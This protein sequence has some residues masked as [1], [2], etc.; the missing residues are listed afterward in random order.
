MP[1]LRISALAALVIAYALGPMAT[2]IAT[3]A[4]PF[5]HRDF[6]IS[7]AAAQTMISVAFAVIAVLR[8]Y[9]LPRRTALAAPWPPMR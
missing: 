6:G 4:V 3:P 2:Q 5:V 9:W 8:G 1:R 7:M